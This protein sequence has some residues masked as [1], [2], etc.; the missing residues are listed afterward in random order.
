MPRAAN[1]S[2]CVST[3]EGALTRSSSG[4]TREARRAVVRV[5]RLGSTVLMD[6]AAVIVGRDCDATPLDGLLPLHLFARV[7]F[8]GPERQLLIEAR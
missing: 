3:N 1:A 2:V 7:T 8:N 4:L 5:F 6:V